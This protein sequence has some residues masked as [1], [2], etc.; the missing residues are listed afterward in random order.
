MHRVHPRRRKIGYKG[1]PLTS[2]DDLGFNK[3]FLGLFS[4]LN[5]VY[6]RSVQH[7][8]C[9]Y[10]NDMWL[11]NAKDTLLIHDG[12][13]RGNKCL[14]NETVLKIEKRKVKLGEMIERAPDFMEFDAVQSEAIGSE[15]RTS[16][17]QGDEYQEGDE[18]IESEV[19]RGGEL[20]VGGGWWW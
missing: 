17:P 10:C 7:M 11:S 16:D 8:T 13:T 5:N 15:E 9:G 14:C 20:V 3:F 2:I 1:P 12:F 19:V 4:D 18:K 6:N